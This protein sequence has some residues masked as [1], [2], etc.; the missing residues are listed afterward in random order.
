MRG[1]NLTCKFECGEAS[2]ARTGLQS[3]VV[4]QSRLEPGD[5]GAD[6]GRGLAHDDAYRGRLAG[7]FDADGYHVAV[8]LAW[9]AGGQPGGSGGSAQAAAG[10]ADVDAVERERDGRADD[11]ERDHAGAF[12]GAHVCAGR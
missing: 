12:V 10:D 3:A 8:L 11:C 9:A 5:V 7:G 2:T 4:D 6:G 1:G